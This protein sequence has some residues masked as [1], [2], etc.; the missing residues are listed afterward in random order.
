M[1]TNEDMMGN[2]KRKLISMFYKI[3]N[4]L[5]IVINHADLVS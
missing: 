4:I 2:Y 5:L 1:L 3:L